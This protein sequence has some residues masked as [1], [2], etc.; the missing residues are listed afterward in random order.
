MMASKQP[1]IVSRDQWLKARL[2]HLKSEKAL[3]RMRDMVA[4][5]RRALPW[6]RLDKEYTF[7]TTVGKQTLGDLFRGRSQL[8]VQHF[9]FGPDWDAGCPGCSLAADHA[10]GAIVH[11][12]NHDV[13]YVRISRASL[14]KLQAYNK[15]MGWTALWVS[16]QN[17]DFNYDFHVSFRPED[18]VGGER[19][20]NYR[21]LND[22]RYQEEELPGLSV[23]CRDQS[24]IIYHT[25]SSYA[26]GNEEISSAFV[27]LDLTPKGRNE[28]EIMDWLR[29]HDEYESSNKAHNCC[30]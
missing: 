10:E 6:V 25:Y 27:Y 1:R 22:D 7:D 18:T 20:Y 11:L 14:D 17:S 12:E 13:A 26:R 23:F 15:R 24:G 30:A 3:T 8:V 21:T 19:Y 5:E 9:M 29:R 16:S 28:K 2:A 4:A